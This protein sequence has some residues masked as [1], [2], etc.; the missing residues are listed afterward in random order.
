MSE[1]GATVN[2]G[3]RVKTAAVFT[4]LGL[5]T[6]VDPDTVKCIV[7]APGSPATETE[8]VYGVDAEVVKTATGTYE[9]LQLISAAGTWWF[10]WAAISTIAGLNVTEELAVRGEGTVV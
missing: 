3:T 8:Y 2:V 1:L 4:P 10:H 6:P 9:L 5:S 7:R